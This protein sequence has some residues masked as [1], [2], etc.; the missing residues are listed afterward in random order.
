MNDE[1]LKLSMRNTTEAIAQLGQMTRER[2]EYRERVE[3][4]RGDARRDDG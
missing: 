3:E 1:D 2:D 4:L